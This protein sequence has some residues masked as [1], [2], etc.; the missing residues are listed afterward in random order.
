MF[1]LLVLTASY[2]AGIILR[3][4]KCQQV[5]PQPF[6]TR[7]AQLSVFVVAQAETCWVQFD[8]R[9][10]ARQMRWADVTDQDGVE[11]TWCWTT[12]AAFLRADAFLSRPVQEYVRRRCALTLST[13]DG[14]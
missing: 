8:T 2:V 13:P 9:S 3:Q 1:S 12:E 5:C 11:L 4:E 10:L 7:H 6:L 14:A